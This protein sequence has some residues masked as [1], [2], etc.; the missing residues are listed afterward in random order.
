MNINVLDAPQRALSFVISQAQRI[1]REV[2]EVVYRDIQYPE[3]VP[4]DTA[5]P[6][7]ISGVTYFST[8]AVGRMN[9]FHGKGDD[10][11]HADVLREKFEAGISMAAIGYDFDTEE[12][13][14]AMQLGLD[15]RNDKANAA[16]RAAEEFTDRI[17]LSGDTTKNYYGL[18]N[19]PS[20]T[21]GS[22]PADGTGSA[23]TFAS[24]SADFVL[25][26]IN[27]AISGIYT[28][29]LGA[30]MADT[31]LLPIQQLQDLS[32]RRIDTTN[33]TTILE[34]VER[35]NVYTRMTGR[36]LTIRGV[37]ALA[38]AGSGSTARMVAYRRDPAVV[39]L[40]MPMPF[41][42]LPVWQQ[43]PMKFEVPAIMR[44]SGVECRRPKAMRYMDGI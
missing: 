34:W 30:E 27:S 28:G 17:A 31:L 44:L 41:R 15:I 21:A 39:V 29:T 38:T 20:V 19:Q 13:G 18:L 3:L 33:Q 22:A 7:W 35:N 11:P 14:K 37:W 2:Y 25:R 36:P 32:T 6:E 40:Y 42:F 23:T 12:V 8:D 4:V 10:V 5:G 24:K 9:W 16:R 1:E 26:D 43:G